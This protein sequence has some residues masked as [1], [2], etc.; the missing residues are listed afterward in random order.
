MVSN[1]QYNETCHFLISKIH[2]WFSC[3]FILFIEIVFTQ[4]ENFTNCVWYIAMW[5]S[6][7]TFVV[8]E[9][10]ELNMLDYFAVNSIRDCMRAT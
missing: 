6:K 9:E 7:K 10:T 5:K 3:Q 2:N 8:D 4:V 1:T